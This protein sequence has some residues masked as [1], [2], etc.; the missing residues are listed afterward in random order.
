MTSVPEAT[1]THG[2]VAGRWRAHRDAAGATS[3]HAIFLGI[4]YAAPPVGDLRFAGPQPPAP[5]DGV[6]PA[7]VY[8][9]TPQRVSPYSPARIPEPSIPG[10]DTLTVNVTTPDPSGSARLPVLVWIHGGGFIGGS[11]ASPWYGGQALARD[12]VVTVTVSYRLAF[13]GFG[14]VDDGENGNAV[15]NR[16]VRDWL[17]ALEWVQRNIAAF[18]GDP[19]RVT[20]AG[21]SAGGSAVMRLLA[22]RTAQHLFRGALAVSPADVPA[23][24]DDAR[25]IS[26]RIAVRVGVAPTAAGFATVDERTLFDARVAGF[27]H[28]VPDALVGLVAEAAQMPA[29]TPAIDGDLIED[30]VVNALA[31]G[32]GA[33]KPLLIGATAHEF[34]DTANGIEHLAEG[35]DTAEVLVAAG[36]PADLAHDMATRDA[37]LGTAWGVA[38]AFSDIVFRRCVPGFANARVGE[39]TWAYDFRW[40]PREP[41][42]QGGEGGGV[43]GAL[44]CVDVPFA[45]DILGA[46]GVREVLGDNPPQQLADA[47]H[48]DWL[49]LIRDGHLDANRWDA[50]RTTVTYGIHGDRSVGQAYGLEER[51]WRATNPETTPA[52]NQGKP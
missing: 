39:P 45:F 7:W 44:H 51:L 26:R 37:H 20:I 5:W 38:Q 31:A 46:P 36:L 9:A 25:D 40:E 28:P 8:G 14:W 15:N 27:E 22:M 10:A 52:I 17:A 19:A 3:T 18:G 6:R 34:N 32:V 24:A 30:S 49:A 12:G 1:T 11:P 16:G 35:R 50:T 47:V 43:E 2:R 41:G 29:L 13:E 42:T 48:G 4:P 33:G 21:Q 23:T